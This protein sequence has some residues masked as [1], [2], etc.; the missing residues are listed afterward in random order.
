MRRCRPGTR[1]GGR[2]AFADLAHEWF[3][4]FKGY[5]AYSPFPPLTAPKRALLRLED[6]HPRRQGNSPFPHRCAQPTHARFE[7]E[8]EWNVQSE[9]KKINVSRLGREPSINL[10]NSGIPSSILRQE[11]AEMSPVTPHLRLLRRGDIIICQAVL[12]FS[13]LAGWTAPAR[14]GD[15]LHRGKGTRQWTTLC[16]R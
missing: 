8:V 15:N 10:H 16:F 11:F 9:A 12:T 7:Q 13:L 6:D 14:A 1:R 3:F 2:I 4:R 5:S